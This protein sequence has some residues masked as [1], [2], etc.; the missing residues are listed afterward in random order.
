MDIR[1]LLSSDDGVPFIRVHFQGLTILLFHSVGLPLLVDRLHLR[2]P[3]AAPRFPVLACPGHAARAAREGLHQLEH[4]HPAA[5]LSAL[6]EEAPG[7]AALRGE[8]LQL[9]GPET[10]RLPTGKVN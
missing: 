8:V 2:R 1:L 3:H 7:Q 6:A 5:R 9:E 4:H 10:M